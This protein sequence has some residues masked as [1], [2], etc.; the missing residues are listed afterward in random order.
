MGRL[1]GPPLRALALRTGRLTS[2]GGDE[3]IVRL[4]RQAGRRDLAP[5][6]YL[7]QQ[8]RDALL[9]AAFGG[10]A[11]AILLRAPVAALVAAVAGF[12]VGLTRTRRRLEREVG[13]R[14]ERI[15]LEL[16]TVNHLLAMQVR[17]GAG[18]IQAVQRLVERGHGAVASCET[19]WCGSVVAW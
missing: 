8:L 6:D 19:S 4:L 7:V 9:G 18:P 5:D 16:Y 2:T 15:R 1:F 12:V 10:A 17:T 13:E 3:A 11:V 14:A